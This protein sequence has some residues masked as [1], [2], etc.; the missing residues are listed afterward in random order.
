[1][2]WLN[3]RSRNV[4]RTHLT[5]RISH[6]IITSDPKYYIARMQ[7]WSMA[8]MCCI[9]KAVIYVWDRYVEISNKILKA[10]APYILS[11]LTYIF[12]KVLSSGIFPNR[13]KYSEIQP[14]YKKAEKTKIANY[15]PISFLSSFSKIIEKVIYKRWNCFLIENN[16]LTNEQFWF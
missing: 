10:S 12:N 6:N 8:E 16:I 5:C 9:L 13:L 7:L 4:F 1:M 15:R 3:S 11:P 14:L 2:D